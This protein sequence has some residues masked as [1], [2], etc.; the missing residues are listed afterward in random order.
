MTVPFS[1]RTSWNLLT[2]KY[3]DALQ[4]MRAGDAPFCMDTAV[5]TIKHF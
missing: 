1:A 3:A 2:T 5:L 4:A